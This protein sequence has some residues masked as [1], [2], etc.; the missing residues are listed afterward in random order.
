MQLKGKVSG[1]IFYNAQ[2]GYT[3]LSL[4]A[5]KKEHICVGNFPNL[6]E[7]EELTLE[8]SFSMHSKFG[9]QFSVT[10]YT[11]ETPRSREAVIMYLSN[12]LIKGVGEITAEKIYSHFGADTMD[13]IRDN[14]SRLA[15]VKGISD[16]KAADI[17]NSY[18]AIKDM[19]SQI[20]YLQGLDITVN[21]ALKI[22]NFYKDATKEI[23]STNPYKL[24]DDIEG[25]GFIT[26]DKIARKMGI[27]DNSPFRIRA[28]V[29]Y[30]LKES[31][32]KQGNTFLSEDDLKND[33]IKLL[34]LDLQE[35]YISLWREVLGNL[36]LDVT[37]KSFEVG[38][39]P[40]LSL[41]K[42]HNME[43]AIADKL[44]R[45]NAQSADNTPYK[46]LLEEFERA[47]GLVLHSSQK[48]AVLDALCQG[49]T[50]IT[51][52]PGT[53][54]TTIIKCITHILGKYGKKIE[55]C[56]PTGRASKRLSEASGLNAKTIHRLLG[57]NYSSGSLAFT[58]NQF[59]TLPADVIIIDEVSMVDVGIMYSLLRALDAGA[60]LILVGD[61]D[62]LPSVGAGNVLADIILSGTVSVN[63]LTHIYRQEEG[64]RIVSNAHLINNC[65]MPLYDSASKDFFII[66]KN[67]QEDI[68]QECLALIEKRLPN[69]LKDSAKEIQLLG[70]L[71]GGAAGVN[72]FNKCL[73]ELLNP[74]LKEKRQITVGDTLFRTGDRVM[75]I[76][77]D[78]EQA[79]QKNA[80]QGIEEGEGVFNGDIGV[81]I[82]VSNY[83]G[84]VIVK[85]DDDR[86]AQYNSLTMTNLAL[87]YAMTIHKS[88]GSE[89]DC[90]VIPLVAGAPTI[91][92]KNLLYT[93]VT[94]AKKVVVLV[95]SKKVLSM[96]VHNNYIAQR[97]TLLKKFLQEE[98]EKYGL[99]LKK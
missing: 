26:A 69:W 63:Y 33:C 41:S 9:E 40:C 48:S 22:Y 21:T 87:A 55:L 17:S 97:T 32:E 74:P 13:I 18:R 19:Q 94:R 89:F 84:S 29:I 43:K 56:A 79:W 46:D 66:E 77:N 54:K 23:V 31:A 2:N 64:S 99:L 90:V 1:I 59:N 7:G 91:L 83:S 92:N 49:V 50:V 93:A 12:G 81:I 72:N 47:E 70:A 44:L 96:V 60:K 37:V 5:G 95:C 61:K 88:Q 57:V 85:F 80:E 45:L 35:T 15:E 53:G 20:L 68:L 25:I 3:V 38:T 39:T 14:P 75:Q 98:R 52:G 42:F 71:K 6:C 30:C 36:T 51:G 11:V 86:V 62:Q 82:E 34:Q 10:S 8:G 27:E 4:D 16:A 73:Q 67:G 28:A 65:R 76:V 58:Y 24:I 78:Y